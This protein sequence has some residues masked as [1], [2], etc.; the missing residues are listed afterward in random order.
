MPG[1]MRNR[2][3]LEEEEDDDEEE[4]TSSESSGPVTAP[5]RSAKKRP[6]LSNG[7]DEVDDSWMLSPPATVRRGQQ[8]Q[9]RAPSNHGPRAD[10][11]ISSTGGA[12]TDPN[13]FK[14]GQLLKV[15]V[16]NFVT[17][18][19]A[20]FLPGPSLNM[21]IGPNGTGKS[22][23]VCAI[24]IGLGFSTAHLGRA[25]ELSEF[26]KH[27]TK[28]ASIEIQLKGF[29]GRTDKTIRL[30]FQRDG[31][32]KQW[33]L[34]GQQCRAK[35]IHRQI[36][37]FGIQVDNLCH[38]LPQDRVVEFSRLNAKDRLSSTLRA[39][40]PAEIVEYHEQLK[41]LAV[42]RRKV[43]TEQDERQQQLKQLERRQESQRGDVER[44][45]KRTEIINKR[46]KLQKLFPIARHNEARA[47][48]L[49][50]KGK[51]A[52]L[53]QDLTRLNNLVQP[54]DEAVKSKKAYHDKVT[55]VV[56]G[57]RKL[58]D[59][60]ETQANKLRQEQE[61]NE[62]KVK[63]LD[64][65]KDNEKKALNVRKKQT[66]D[67]QGH[68][69]RV[70]AQMEQAPIE[71]DAADFNRRIN[72]KTREARTLQQQVLDIRESA[73]DRDRQMREKQRQV[74][75]TKE[76]LSNLHSQSGQMRNKLA[77]LSQD[78]V[79]AWDWIKNNQHRFKKAVHGPPLLT[80]SVKDARYA[81]MIES[82]F[83]PKDVLRITCTDVEDW[84][85][86]Q[87]YL[88]EEL[89]LYDFALFNS[90]TKLEEFQRPLN[91]DQMRGLGLEGWA[92]DFLEGP[93]DV[94]SMLCDYARIHT[95]GIVWQ[96][97]NNQ[98][99]NAL[100]DSGLSNWVTS[101]NTYRVTRRKEYGDAAKSTRVVAIADRAKYWA[102]QGVDVNA[103]A[104][105]KR[106]IA[107]LEDEISQM[108]DVRNNTRKHIDDIQ[109]SIKKLEDEKV[110]NFAWICF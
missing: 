36:A 86:L 57:R 67:L 32:K 104:N 11:T 1:I 16:R 2:S 38:F 72:D 3:S 29:P 52:A 108:E 100:Q 75:Q 26:V 95:T 9:S 4:S 44:M 91:E 70:E 42:N 78:T 48:F 55:K 90:K 15:H 13:E 101:R 22:T 46:N 93:D 45:R 56:D 60:V 8:Q 102:S 33:S 49:E 74:Q 43:H 80:C 10:S 58:C 59:M 97:V 82:L 94:L 6:R 54:F 99:F 96:D 69:S 65:R 51:R 35:D 24:C 77:Q 61:A 37:Q 28:D 66:S 89:H 71:F 34:D 27:G 19:D 5:P 81:T 92:I 88:S 106:Q 53:D 85:F 17:Y 41:N 21:V 110:T 31:D 12:P 50:A 76:E 39:A 107:E 84:K 73:S 103:E 98:Q 40:A 47:A 14:P 79:K 64:Q 68:I 87:K 109:T 20:T 18:T 83:G 62:T 63:A 25:K 23:L 105:L 7:N 30:D